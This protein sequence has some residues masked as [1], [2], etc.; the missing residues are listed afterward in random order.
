MVRRCGR[1]RSAT[2]MARSPQAPVEQAGARGRVASGSRTCALAEISCRS[3]LGRHAGC[4]HGK[5]IAKLWRWCDDTTCALP[6]SALPASETR[7]FRM[8]GH[9]VWA[10]PFSIACKAEVQALDTRPAL[11]WNSEVYHGDK[12]VKG[13]S[14]TVEKRKASQPQK[15]R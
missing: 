13:R 7:R 1:L 3:R 10:G 15:P 2:R 5:R 11:P 9:R 6:G 14:H 12:R 8:H 4:M